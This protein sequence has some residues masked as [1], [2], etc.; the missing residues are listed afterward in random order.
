MKNRRR[1]FLEQGH[2]QPTEAI[3][4]PDD[5]LVKSKNAGL[6]D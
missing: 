2:D 6:R 1:E 4:G 5:N 3:I